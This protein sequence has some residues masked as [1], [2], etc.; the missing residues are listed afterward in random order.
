MLNKYLT[1]LLLLPVALLTYF[2]GFHSTHPVTHGTHNEALLV[3]QNE[4][5]DFNRVK[6]WIQDLQSQEDTKRKTARDNII[7]Y[8]AKSPESRKIV[9]EGLLELV[10][11]TGGCAELTKYPSRLSEWREAVD[12]L[13]TIR[14]TESIDMLINSLNCSYG[15]SGLGPERYPATLAVIKMGE[16]AIPNLANAL[17]QKPVEI[18]FRAVQALYVIGGDRAKEVLKKAAN[19]DRQ[20]ASV[21]KDMLRKWNDSGKSIS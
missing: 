14:A 15:P 20:L 5:E 1:L 8:S 6:A 2:I 13:G 19:K 3:N 10:N 12:I 7:A 11:I 16:G 4:Q 9:I 18:R 21:I 17:E